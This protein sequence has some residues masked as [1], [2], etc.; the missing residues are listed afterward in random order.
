ML[1]AGFS[2]ALGQVSALPPPATHKTR[3]PARRPA[4]ARTPA[5]DPRH[6]LNSYRRGCIPGQIA[7]S[8]RP[9][10]LCAHGG[11]ETRTLMR[12]KMVRPG[13]VGLCSNSGH[14]GNTE[15]GS[16]PRAGPALGTGGRRTDDP[17][18]AGLHRAALQSARVHRSIA[19]S[20]P[21]L[22]GVTPRYYLS[23]YGRGPLD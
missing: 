5:P 3:E 21:L 14:R 7:R 13:R 23:G 15:R 20:I 1:R 17:G 9:R 16:Q 8:G 22:A 12:V 10:H 6:H 4:H 18:A 11:P 19:T 2:S